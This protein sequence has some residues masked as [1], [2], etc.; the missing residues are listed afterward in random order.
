MNKDDNSL[1][2][3]CAWISIRFF[4]RNIV[5]E[6]AKADYRNY[7]LRRISNLDPSVTAITFF[8]SSPYSTRCLLYFTAL[9]FLLHIL[10]LTV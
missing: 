2:L 5:A 8:S 6:A 1:F 10:N 9:F 3:C 4:L 7:R